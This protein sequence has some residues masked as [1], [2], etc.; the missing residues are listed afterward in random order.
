M[1]LNKTILRNFNK[2]G[3]VLIKNLI[4]KN[5]LKSISKR[6]LHLSKSQKDGRGL[7]EPG[8]KKS[9]VHSIHND[10][11]FNKIIKKN[12]YNDISCHLLGC[13]NIY[14]WNAKSNLKKRWIGSAEY[15]HQ[16]YIYWKGLGSSSQLE[17]H[18]FGSHSPDRAGISPFAARPHGRGICS[19]ARRPQ[20]LRRPSPPNPSCHRR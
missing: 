6:L 17:V 4:K 7:S 19:R 5:D 2:D 15:F 1:K 8:T 16:D 13:K 11:I 20:H 10:I 9:L 3:F 18:T 12:W 14:T